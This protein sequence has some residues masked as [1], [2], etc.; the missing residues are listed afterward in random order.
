M[1]L[2]ARRARKA[3]KQWIG[4]KDFIRQR[5]EAF[6]TGTGGHLLEV[7]VMRP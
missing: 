3:V 7:L 4:G 5:A 1:W 6:L 2:V